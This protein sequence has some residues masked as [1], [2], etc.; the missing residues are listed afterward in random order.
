MMYNQWL[1]GFVWIE[2]SEKYTFCT[3][4]ISR[5]FQFFA[6][7]LLILQARIYNSEPP[8]LRTCNTNL[9]RL[10]QQLLHG[11][12]KQNQTELYCS[13]FNV[14]LPFFLL[15]PNPRLKE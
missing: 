3:T 14:A 15:D 11:S 5:M 12:K 10:K 8:Q 7:L 2:P 13:I 1:V 6:L 4:Q 9:S